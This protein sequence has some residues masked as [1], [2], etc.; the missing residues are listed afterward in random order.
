[1][2]EDFL[3]QQD[4]YRHALAMLIGMPRLFVIVML[5]PFLGTAVVTG[6]LRMVLV[7]SMYLLLHNYIVSTLPDIS[8]AEFAISLTYGVIVIKEIVLGLLIGYL[9]AL[10]FWAIQS[11]GFFIDNQRGASSAE[12]SEIIS[13]DSISPTGGLFFQSVVYLFFAGGG[14][15]S[16]LSIIYMSYEIFPPGQMLT[17]NID[18]AVALFYADKLGWIFLHMLLL[19]SPIAVAC[20]LTDVSLG[21]INRFASQLNVYVLAMPIKSGLASLLLVF[22]FAVFVGL[23]PNLYSDINGFVIDLGGMLK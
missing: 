22:Y 9:G 1:M 12:G 21:L 23:M 8:A 20:L 16:Y 14:F 10:L 3:N 2:I 4:Q 17:I 18:M 13:G 15:L 5:A 11:A 7:T 19:A 6:Q